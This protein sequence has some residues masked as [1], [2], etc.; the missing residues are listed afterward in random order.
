MARI[1][2]APDSSFRDALAEAYI[3]NDGMN[4]LLLEYL[5]PRAWRLKPAGAGARPIVASSRTCIT[6]GGSGFGC[7]RRTSNCQQSSIA[8]GAH[9]G[10]RE[11]ALANSAGE[12]ADMIREALWARGTRT[13]VSS[14]RVGA[15]V[16]VRCGDVYVYGCHDAHHRGQVCM[17]A[18]Q[19][20]YKLPMKAVS[21][22]VE[23]GEI[24]EGLRIRGA[25]VMP[26]VGCVASGWERRWALML[27][28]ARRARRR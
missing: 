4:Q 18:H 22:D 19:L 27:M 17:L 1:A 11:L 23:L 12:C 21:C 2:S 13:A 5:D 7:R 8:R 3:V 26:S 20:G 16:A 24:V 10:R 9:R 25:A 28:R 15:D 14:G 6:C